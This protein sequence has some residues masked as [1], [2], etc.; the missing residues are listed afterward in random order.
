M[1]NKDIFNKKGIV[2]LEGKIICLP[3]HPTQP[4]G[5]PSQITQRKTPRCL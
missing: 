5:L 2:M 1:K 4:S 3:N